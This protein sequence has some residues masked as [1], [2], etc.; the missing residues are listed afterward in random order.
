VAVVEVTVVPIGTGDSSLSRHVAAALEPLEQSGLKFELSSMGTSIEG[1][2]DEILKVI[3][4]MHETP[5]LAGIKRVLTRVVIDDRRDK[6]IS[7]DGKKKSV[8]EKG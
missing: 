5:F 1:P 8:K 7:I 2:L 6:E 3:M 4:K